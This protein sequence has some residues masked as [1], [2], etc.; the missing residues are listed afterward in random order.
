MRC[1]VSSRQVGPGVKSF[2]VGDRVAISPTGRTRPGLGRDGGYSHKCVAYS[3]DLV[4][5][6]D[7]LDYAVAAVGTD[8][9][10]AAYRALVHRGQVEAGDNVG[11]IGLGGL[12]Q[13]GAQIATY[14]GATVYAAEINEKIWHMASRLGVRRVSRDISDFSEIEFDLI[15]DFAGFGET[16]SSAIHAVKP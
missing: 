14:V 15:V 6:P 3:E 11:I 4:K 2:S 1:L 9:A 8:A 13:F 5:L 16:T 12:G 7:E 10:R